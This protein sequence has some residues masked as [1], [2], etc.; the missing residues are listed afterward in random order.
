MMTT[1]NASQLWSDSAGERLAAA[2]ALSEAALVEAHAELR[3]GLATADWP[4]GFA[5]SIN[6]MLVTLGVSPGSARSWKG[7][8]PATEPFAAPTA[9]QS[10]PHLTAMRRATPFG[11]RI[12]HLA[13]TV[14]KVGDLT[15]EDAYALFGNV[16]LD[17]GRSGAASDV[18]LRPQIAGRVLRVIRDQLRP[19][20]LICFGMKGHRDAGRL[21]EQT[22]DGF[23][24]SRPSRQDRFRSYE[25]RHLTFQEWDVEGPSGNKI[26]IV[27]WPQHPRRAPFSDLDIWQAA[28]RE[29]AERHGADIRP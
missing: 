22:F 29:F 17:P 16:V 27:F 23:T 8:D 3:A 6:P 20:H 26:V 14:L 24:R 18:R 12:R 10:H 15:D 9:G 4:Y 2:R 25:R 11:D 7:R 1:I 19:R 21:L 28:C 5:T 13:R